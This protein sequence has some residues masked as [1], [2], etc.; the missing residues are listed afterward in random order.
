MLVVQLLVSLCHAHAASP[1]RLSRALQAPLARGAL[2]GVAPHHR[3]SSVCARFGDASPWCASARATAAGSWRG[4]RGSFLSWL[5]LG[6]SCTYSG[7]SVDRLKR[8]VRSTHRRAQKT[9]GWRCWFCTCW[10][11]SEVLLSAQA[12]AAL[13]PHA[14]LSV[15]L[16][17]AAG[18]QVQ[19]VVCHSLLPATHRPL[20]A[21]PLTPLYAGQ[22][23]LE[24]SFWTERVGAELGAGGGAAASGGAA[25]QGAAGARPRG[26][27]GFGLLV[28]GGAV[29]W[30]VL[31]PHVSCTLA[32]EWGLSSVAACR[33]LTCPAVHACSCAA[34]RV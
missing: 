26:E 24:V 7:W 27:R 23:N 28:E 15:Q 11:A 17:G 32:K 1:R 12:W 6:G 19:P 31:Q 9:G 10:P 8:L 20:C 18:V 21:L 34:G 3:S 16:F 5:G 13:Q 4:R 33:P 29:S 2:C 25:E 14:S 30:L 22:C